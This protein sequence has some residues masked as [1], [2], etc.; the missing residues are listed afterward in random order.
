MTSEGDLRADLLAALAAPPG[1]DRVEAAAGVVRRAEL[2]GHDAFAHAA[3]WEL[4]VAAL[5][6]DLGDDFVL[7]TFAR[8]VAEHDADPAAS[9]AAPHEVVAAQVVVLRYVT[10]YPAIPR[11]RVEELLAD[12]ARRSAADGH[13]RVEAAEAELHARADLGDLEE[14]PRLLRAV[15]DARD[16]L[17][18]AL[19]RRDRAV[20]GIYTGH[21]GHALAAMRPVTGGTDPDDSGLKS[22]FLAWSLRP[23]VWAGF[24]EEA[25]AV[26]PRVLASSRTWFFGKIMALEY[27]ARV[28]DAAA[29]GPLLREVLTA[30][31][32]LGPDFRMQAWHTGGLACERL[33]GAGDRP[34]SLVLPGE[35]GATRV[36]PSEAAPVLL[37][38][39]AAIAADLDARNGNDHVSRHLAGNR[40]FA[41]GPG[42][43]VDRVPAERRAVLRSL[44]AEQCPPG[45][46]ADHAADHAGET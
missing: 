27:A 36:R 35:E 24:E 31:G 23:L 18:P 4:L 19:T 9:V 38:A 37:A 2:A 44:W 28:A 39:G 15:A 11:A 20:A 12:L 45:T 42:T 17:A 43:G 5:S 33:A 6:T 21:A 46:F 13:G 7:P 14:V 29:V 26:F 40:D 32:H 8:F 10:R 30:A 3:R 25:A 16:G 22:T 1:R 34:R 41:F